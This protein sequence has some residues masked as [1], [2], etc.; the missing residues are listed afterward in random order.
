MTNPS[1]ARQQAVSPSRG[2]FPSRDRQ[3][4]GQGKSDRNRF[5]SRDRE[6]AVADTP[7]LRLVLPRK[8]S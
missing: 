2:R 3:V 5:P 6:G 4:A 1:R 8:A 7:L